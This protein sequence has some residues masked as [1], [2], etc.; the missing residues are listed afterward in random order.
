M[1]ESLSATRTRAWRVWLFNP[2]HYVAGGTALVAG[3]LI[4]VVTSLNG[5]LSHSHFDGVL[6]FHTGAAAPWWVYVAEGLIDWLVMGV[7]AYAAGRIVSASQFR[8]VDVFG[9]QALARTPALTM[10]VAAMLPGFQR[11]TERFVTMNPE[12][13]VGDVMQFAA[14][15]VGILVA[16]IWMVLLMYRAFSVSCNAKGTRAVVAFIVA[17]LV[18]EGVSK[19]AIAVMLNAVIAQ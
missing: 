10:P 2:F 15:I 17:L 9:T 13:H 11:Q 18:A 6:D 12:I 3:L 7:L 4:I 16:L 1:T 14:G 19:G 5:A 8:A